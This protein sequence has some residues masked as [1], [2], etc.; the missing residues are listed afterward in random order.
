M[1]ETTFHLH[2]CMALDGVG[3]KRIAGITSDS[4]IIRLL[5]PRARFSLRLDPGLLPTTARVA[6]FTLDMVV[7]RRMATGEK[8][9]MRLGPDEWLL[10]GTEGEAAQIAVDVGAALAGLHHGLVDVGHHYVAL[11]VSGPRAADVVNSGCP[12]DLSPAAFPAGSAT[13]TLLGKAEVVLAKTDD[14][15][16][17]EVA[18]GRS[19]AAYVH[20]FLLEAAR[21]LG[22]RP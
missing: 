20:D 3:A 15:P 9:A 18:C 12:L 21:E 6:G 5:A 1:A 14:V 10:S 8:A 11:S 2:R 4:V 22:V 19:F 16:A 13:R 17:F 7:N